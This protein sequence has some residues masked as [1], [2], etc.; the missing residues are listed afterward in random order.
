[1]SASLQE[2]LEAKIIE[3]LNQM[4]HEYDFKEMM[5]AAV[6]EENIRQA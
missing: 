1:M 5:Q 3:D 4:I 6:E 2:D